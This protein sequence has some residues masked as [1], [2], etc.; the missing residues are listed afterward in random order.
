MRES[1]WGDRPDG[2]LGRLEAKSFVWRTSNGPQLWWELKYVLRAVGYVPRNRNT[3]RHAVVNRQLAHWKAWWLLAGLPID[4][5]S[6]ASARSLRLASGTSARA[7]LNALAEYSVTTEALCVMLAH[8]PTYRRQ[9]SSKAQAFAPFR[10]FLEM[11]TERDDLLA[12]LVR[13]LEVAA[14]TA[15][16]AHPV[17]RGKGRCV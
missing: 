12:L 13:T 11:V 1:P 15:C 5:S 16:S 14:C 4:S 9:Q 8:W 10:L 6:Y 2:D 3:M 7:L 17:V